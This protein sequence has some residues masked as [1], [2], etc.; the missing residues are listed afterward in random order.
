M[1][2][3]IKEKGY[4]LL[5]DEVL[6]VFEKAPFVKTDIEHLEKLGLIEQHNGMYSLTEDGY[7]YNGTLM[8]EILSYAACREIFSFSDNDD[9]LYYWSLP[10][11]YITAFTEV[12]VMTY[13]FSGQAMSMYLEMNG[14]DYVYIGV[15]RDASGNHQFTREIR[16]TPFEAESE[17]RLRGLI[18]VVDDSKLNENF[19]SDG[20][21]GR[22]T[23]GSM[24]WYDRNSESV[25]Q[26]RKNMQN[27]Y[28]HRLDNEGRR[29]FMWGTYCGDRD[30][31]RGDGY[32]RKFVPFNSRATNEFRDRTHLA[33]A[34]N[35]FM[36][37]GEKQFLLDNGYEPNEDAYALSILLQWIWRSAI[38]DGKPV[39]LYLPIPRMRELL[40]DWLDS[41]EQ[42]EKS[43]VGGDPT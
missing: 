2:E 35:P 36:N 14:V 34:A 23:A 21:R 13:M 15:C 43:D 4:T 22:K 30:K 32:S 37:V 5:L 12:I 39:E 11:M 25:E 7:R 41:V 10:I 40:N 8:A 1:L 17:M 20:K 26:L 6:S 24:A 29:K 3:A 9:M 38:R 18:S 31:L 16:E 27:Y 42:R 33:Y 28:K 19:L